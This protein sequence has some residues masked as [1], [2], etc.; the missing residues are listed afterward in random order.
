MSNSPQKKPTSTAQL[1]EEIMK[2]M[3]EI[4][5]KQ[6]E[7]QEMQAQLELANASGATMA[8]SNG[9]KTIQFNASGFTQ[10]ADFTAPPK[11]L[12]PTHYEVAPKT[13]SNS[14]PL[15]KNNNTSTAK[16]SAKKPVADSPSK[17]T[18]VKVSYDDHIE[19]PAMR[20]TAYTQPQQETRA[21]TYTTV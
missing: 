3:N 11:N 12:S 16:K 2:R 19:P 18:Y 21:Q 1:Q 7:I 13:V 15:R 4:A 10:I 17:H 14:S 9:V 8:D 6:K 20:Q 5:Q